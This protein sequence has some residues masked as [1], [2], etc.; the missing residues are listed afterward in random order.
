MGVMLASWPPFC[1]SSTVLSCNATSQGCKFIEDTVTSNVL[2]S[3]LLTEW[4]EDQQR[5]GLA[6]TGE[7]VGHA[8]TQVHCSLSGSAPPVSW[9]HLKV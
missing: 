9:G 7:L 6:N 2:W 4:S 8:E 3:L 1:Y 5:G